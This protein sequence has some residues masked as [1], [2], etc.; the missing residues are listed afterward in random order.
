MKQQR[1]E[2][3]SRLPAS[4][5]F[6]ERAIEVSPL[7]LEFARDFAAFPV[8]PPA[9]AH[10]KFKGRLAREKRIML[11]QIAEPQFRVADDF[12]PIEFLFAQENSQEGAFSRSVAADKPY[13][14]VIS[15]RG[16]GPV[17]QYLVSITLVSISDL[18]QHSHSIVILED[19]LDETGPSPV[20][21]GPVIITD[22]V[23]E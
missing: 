21:R 8:G 10:Q 11:P 1:G 23:G 13:L 9:V 19:V 3:H 4:G 16:F 20:G 15:Q 6:C 7:E 18:Q 17:E 2:F 14:Y 12:S 5:E 22:L